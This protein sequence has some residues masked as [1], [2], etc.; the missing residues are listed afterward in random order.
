M[1]A[2][3]NKG[4]LSNEKNVEATKFLLVITFVFVPF[5]LENLVYEGLTRQG[6]SNLIAGNI[7]GILITVTLLTAGYFTLKTSR[8]DWSWKQVGVRFF[9]RSH[10][11]FLLKL[12][13][14]SFFVSILSYLLPVWFGVDAQNEKS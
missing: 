9:D 3:K 14:L 5:V 1:K 8:E 6:Y 12:S 10:F 11:P 13:I 2:N 7:V 4:R